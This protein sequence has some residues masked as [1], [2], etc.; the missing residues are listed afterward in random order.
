MNSASV[1]TRFS[2]DSEPCSPG[3]VSD[4]DTLASDK[5]YSVHL[6][7]NSK[8]IRAA[9]R[10]RHEVFSLELDAVKGTSRIEFD[11][12]DFRSEHL[13][14]IDKSRGEII[15]TYR[16]NSTEN[17]DDISTL[18]SSGE[19]EIENLPAEVILNGLEI[20]RACISTKHRGS[21]ALLLIWK[22]LAKYLIAQN[23]RFFFGCC[24][25]FTSEPSIGATVYRQLGASGSIH[26]TITVRPRLHGIDIS[27]LRGSTSDC[28][29]PGL[30]E[31]YLK[32]GAKVCG[33]P[34]YDEAFGSIDFFVLFDIAEMSDRYR[35]L[36]GL[37]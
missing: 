5:N 13:V 35:R 31:S 18:Y 4:A 15:G 17:V 28:K 26:P 10:L 21:R 2:I 23:K 19:F 3:L 12:Y 30:F 34:M 22:A 29:L 16:I 9:L 11:A 36:F 25:I 37:A 1:S 33:P 27:D 20:G 14:A 6:A 7:K 32:L 24:S 8:E